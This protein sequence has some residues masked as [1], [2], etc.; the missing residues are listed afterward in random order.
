MHPRLARRGLSSQDDPAAGA[1]KGI[2]WVMQEQPVGWQ[3]DAWKGFA[4]STWK[5][6]FRVLG[7]LAVLM[8]S[9]GCSRWRDARGGWRRDGR[10][11][12]RGPVCGARG[13]GSG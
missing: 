10:G 7:S 12:R 2:D 13:S 5:R 8:V 9:A 4:M 11:E 3:A 1:K 6:A